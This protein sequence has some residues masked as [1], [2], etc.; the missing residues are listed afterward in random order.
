MPKLVSAA[1]T[2]DMVGQDKKNDEEVQQLNV[3]HFSFGGQDITIRCRKSVQSTLNFKL[4]VQVEKEDLYES[5]RGWGGG[6]ESDE[7]GKGPDDSQLV[8]S[9]RDKDLLGLDVWPAAIKLCEY[10][11]QAQFLVQGKRIIELG[12]GVGLPCL[13]AGKL[14]AKEAFISDY[15]TRVVDHAHHNAIECGLGGICRGLLLDWR[16]LENLSPE[17]KHSFDLVLAA[18][19]MYISQIMPDFMKAMDYVMSPAGLAI[20]THQCRQSLV[21]D[22]N[23]QVPIVIDD[24]VSFEKFKDLVSQYGFVMKVLSRDESEGF[25]GP[26]NCLALARE[27]EVLETLVC[28][29]GAR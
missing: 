28:T 9:S 14:G 13:V 19:V 10:L 6:Y 15:D 12:A 27:P 24:D 4:T 29:D 25:P 8:S 18:D 3:E 21:L 5:L 16:R 11:A 26:M 17:H 23:S 22:P 7:D 1:C 2:Q 20:L